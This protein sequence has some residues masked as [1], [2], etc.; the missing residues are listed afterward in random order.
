MVRNPS[1][2]AR[3]EDELEDARGLMKFAHTKG[4]KENVLRKIRYYE[5]QLG[6]DSKPYNG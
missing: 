2:L 3:L 4:E 6:I 5:R 1:E